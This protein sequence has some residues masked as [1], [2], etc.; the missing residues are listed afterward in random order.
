VITVQAGRIQDLSSIPRALEI[1]PSFP[2]PEQ[3]FSQV[4]PVPEDK[5]A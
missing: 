1:L 5:N 4:N 2:N 3:F